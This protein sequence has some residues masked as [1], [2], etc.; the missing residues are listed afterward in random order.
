MI[1]IE[2]KDEIWC[3]IRILPWHVDVKGNSVRYILVNCY[4][5]KLKGVNPKKMLEN[6]SKGR[7]QQD[8]TPAYN[9]K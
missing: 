6:M 5:I 3:S 2:F 9:A 7:F 4:L 1:V 8:G